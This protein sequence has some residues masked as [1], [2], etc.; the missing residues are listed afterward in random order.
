[1]NRRS[2]FPLFLIFV[3]ILSAFVELPH[4]HENTADDH[5]CPTCVASHHTPA[6]SASVAAFDGKPCFAD[7]I[8]PVPA[9]VIPDNIFVSLLNN[10]APPA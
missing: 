3:L 10:R 5:D 8:F 4:H 9:P 7:T 6:V 2:H 1:M